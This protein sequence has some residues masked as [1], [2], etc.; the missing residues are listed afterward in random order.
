[1]SMGYDQESLNRVTEVFIFLRV[2]SP[3]YQRSRRKW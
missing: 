2:E 1:M 3:Y